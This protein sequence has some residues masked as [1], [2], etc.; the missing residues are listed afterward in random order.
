MVS[1][2][3]KTGDILVSRANT[4]ELLGL[5]ALAT[6]D[7]PLTMLCDKLF[8]FRTN[9]SLAY[10]DY[11]VRTIRC[12]SSRAQIESSTN[13]ASSSMQNIGQGV[14]WNLWISLPPVSEQKRILSHI[15]ETNKNIDQ[16]ITRTQREIELMR[17]YRTRL[18]SDV[19]TGKVDVH[20]VEVPKKNCRN[21]MK[22][23]TL[24]FMAMKPI[25][26]L[27]WIRRRL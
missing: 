3:I 6:K 25:S 5:A 7:S 27:I 23:F 15:Q 18:I 11:L 22:R 17:E 8:R 1:L 19:V 14:I 10:P 4:R 26:G 13:G 24:S 20:G 2:S 9:N 21:W 12:P 16:A